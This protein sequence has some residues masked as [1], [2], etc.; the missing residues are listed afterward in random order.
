MLFWGSAFVSGRVLAQSYHPFTVAFLRFFTASLVMVPMLFM[1]SRKPFSLNA[2][3]W[4]TI[5]GLGLTG[6]FAYNFFFF[7]GL[8][9]VEAGKSSV[10]ISMNPAVSAVMATIIFKESFTIRKLI[11]TLLTLFGVLLVITKAHFFDIFKYFHDEMPF[12]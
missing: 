8:S 7:K 12:F 9:L 4:L 1:K 2:K 3:Q 10:I 6:V 11:G 5:L